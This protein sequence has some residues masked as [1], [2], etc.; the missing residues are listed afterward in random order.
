MGS[1][2]NWLKEM[3]VSDRETG[4]WLLNYCKKQGV[5][6]TFRSNSTQRIE[7]AMKEQIIG[8]SVNKPEE[9][10][11]FLLGLREAFRQF[12]YRRGNSSGRDRT[13][14]LS[15]EAIEAIDRLSEETGLSRN[16]VINTLVT[17]TANIRA[18]LEPSKRKGKHLTVN[19]IISPIAREHGVG[20]YVFG[21][22]AY[23]TEHALA[24]KIESVIV[25]LNK[26]ANANAEKVN[27]LDI[28]KAIKLLEKEG[29]IH[30]VHRQI[31]KQSKP[32]LY[33]KPLSRTDVQ[34][35]IED[36]RVEDVFELNDTLVNRLKQ[37]RS[38]RKSV[39]LN[40]KKT[41]L[42]E[43]EVL[44]QLLNDAYEGQSKKLKEQSLADENKQLRQ[45]LARLKGDIDRDLKNIE[46]S[47]K[48]AK[49]VDGCIEALTNRFMALYDDWLSIK[50]EVDTI[51]RDYPGVHPRT[52]VSQHFEN[53]K[54][55]NVRKFRKITKR[56]AVGEA[57][58]SD[59]ES[60]EFTFQPVAES[61]SAGSQGSKK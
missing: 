57:D 1:V 37:Y 56:I 54:R 17:E 43:E 42:S 52:V 40:D 25:K 27:P 34:R 38:H 8:W 26:L 23:P 22:K 5:G 41:I 36:L 4:S 9:K 32:G 30:N 58:K 15:P 60:F 13:Y 51:H 45:E 53:E 39:V 49:Q 16:E 50:L 28:D 59:I 10:H 29:V 21:S 11:K 48:L 31:S 2:P 24:K 46:F 61:P 6:L 14:R 35:D 55:K 19:D 47:D 18:V 44:S 3:D 7:E 33:A 12:E 20:N